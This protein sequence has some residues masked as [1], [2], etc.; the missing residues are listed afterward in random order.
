M[1]GD[2]TILGTP[3][4]DYGKWIERDYQNQQRNNAL[5]GRV[6]G[7]QSKSADAEIGKYQHDLEIDNSKVHRWDEPAARQNGDALMSALFEA[8]QKYGDQYVLNYGRQ[9]A[10]PFLDNQK[11]YVQ[12]KQQLDNAYKDADDQERTSGA[13]DETIKLKDA[14]QK[15]KPG[16]IQ[17][18]KYG[19]VEIAKDDHGLYNVNVNRYAKYDWSKE[20]DGQLSKQKAD[21]QTISTSNPSLAKD[22]AAIPY[23]ER[24]ANFRTQAEA[25]AFGAKYNIPAPVANETAIRNLVE[26]QSHFRSAE[27]EVRDQLPADYSKDLSMKERKKDVGDAMVAKYGGYGAVNY[28]YKVDKIPK[29]KQET[30]S[31]D[32]TTY[33][34]GKNIWNRYV[35]N[36]GV[37]HYAMGHTDATDNKP[38]AFKNDKGEIVNAP[39]VMVD[40]NPKK[41][42][43]PHNP[44]LSV[45]E[46]GSSF[47]YLDKQRPGTTINDYEK[48]VDG[49][50]NLTGN[51]K[52]PD[53]TILD[54]K[55]IQVKPDP[56]AKGSETKLPFG[57]GSN[58]GRYNQQKLQVEFG[59]NIFDVAKKLGGNVSGQT[60]DNSVKS[61][62]STGGSAAPKT[63]V[64]KVGNDGSGYD[65]LKKGDQYY[66]PQG[67]LRT[68]G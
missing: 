56:T 37:H 48:E 59:S 61:N 40:Y 19:N 24:G 43:S 57:N 50:G 49:N 44:E 21:L 66:D 27:Q 38:L 23:I 25:D 36:D 41:P 64:P 9:I 68:K 26:S 45:V 15:G 14:L 58:E 4:S 10:Q 33:T 1:A 16:D 6:R 51:L 32:K 55:D 35:D 20:L 11:M 31:P 54:Q 18:D 46:K 42:L 29:D 13:T 30:V 53:G 52:R 8:K 12:H 47:I 22:P 67:V 7:Q 5:A 2:G 39:N 17:Q 3:N 65:K 34:Q 62:K 63:D 60:Q 28:N